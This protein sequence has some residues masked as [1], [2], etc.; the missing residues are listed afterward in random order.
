MI[1]A[2][3][4]KS[5][6]SKTSVAMMKRKCIKVRHDLLQKAIFIYYKPRKVLVRQGQRAM[7]VYYILSGSVQVEMDVEDSF[8]TKGNVKTTYELNAGDTFGEIAVLYDEPHTTTYTV[9]KCDGLEVLVLSANDYKLIL[10]SSVQKKWSRVR[11]A[12]KKFSCFDKFGEMTLRFFCCGGEIL[13]Y[14]PN[15]NIPVRDSLNRDISTFIIDGSCRVIQ[16][17]MVTKCPPSSKVR[18]ALEKNQDADKV[19]EGKSIYM[20]TCLLKRGAVFGLGEGMSKHMVIAVTEVLVLAIP[21]Y[22]LMKH[23]VARIWTQAAL[24]MDIWYP[25]EE[26]VFKNFLQ[27]RN[28]SIYKKKLLNNNWNKKRTTE[29]TIHDTPLSVRAREIILCDSLYSKTIQEPDYLFVEI[30]EDERNW[31][32]KPQKSN[33]RLQF[34]MGKKGFWEREES[35]R[36]V[37]R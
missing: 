5:K 22:V 23:D 21:R 20:Q 14:R 29:M 7:Y 12:M 9:G 11:W 31:T 28:W 36:Q 24:N 4:S 2:K 10:E 18:Y 6:V 34:S 35:E 32:V 27:G 30:N 16:K 33:T 8:F 15:N 19:K 17:I 25:S 26:E 3:R 1:T 37:H 13:T